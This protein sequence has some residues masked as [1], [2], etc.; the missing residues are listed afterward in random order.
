MRQNDN[1]E[2]YGLKTPK[3]N[4]I[5]PPKRPHSLILPKEF[6]QLG[7]KHSTIRAYGTHSHVNHH[8]WLLENCDL[9][10]HNTLNLF[11]QCKTSTT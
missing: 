2:W 6:Q 3:L 8:T 1:W 10:I 5:P 4:D 7:T 9:R 11:M